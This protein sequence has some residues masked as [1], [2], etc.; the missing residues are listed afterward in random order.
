VSNM[1]LG[2]SRGQLLIAPVRI[3]SRG[4]SR[5]DDQL[6]MCLVL[7]VKS[8]SVKNNIASEPGML[9]P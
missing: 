6:W 4:Q 5:N 3:K 7:K 1:L 2:K 9:G 8:N